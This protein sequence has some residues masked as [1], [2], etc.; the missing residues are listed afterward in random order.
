MVQCEDPSAPV[1][2]GWG[3]WFQRRSVRRDPHPVEDLLSEFG[4]VHP[5]Y[6]A[7]IP[8][9]EA[10]G[11]SANHEVLDETVSVDPTGVVGIFNR[12]S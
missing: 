10:F 8:V 9:T 1:F 11:E 5:R 3:G 4:A 7:R 2:G 12:L 6:D